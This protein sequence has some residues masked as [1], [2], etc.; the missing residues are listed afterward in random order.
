[1]EKIEIRS[2]NGNVLFS[3]EEENNTWKRTVELALLH[4]VSL[5]GAKLS[6]LDLSGANLC[7]ANLSRADLCCANLSRADLCGANLSG[8]DLYAANLR[9]ANL[10]GADLCGASLFVANLRD[11][12]IGRDM[13]IGANLSINNVSCICIVGP[14]GRRLDYTTAYK[15]DKGIYIKC[16]CFFDTIDN[17]AKAVEEKHKGNK[18]EK[19][20]KELIRFIS[21]YFNG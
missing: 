14:I 13:R 10:S 3:H 19:D 4:G 12:I 2:I 21:S 15:T 11:A 8:A 18:H 9:G 16:G 1:M 7:G 5:F 6:D 20:Y 17:F